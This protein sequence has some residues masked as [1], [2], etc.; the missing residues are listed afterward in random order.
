MPDLGATVAI[1]PH[2]GPESNGMKAVASIIAI[3]D[4]HLGTAC[5]GLTDE[6]SD[7]GVDRRDLTPAATLRSAVDFAA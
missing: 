1:N 5:S 2:I 4:V 3:G 6:I 7:W